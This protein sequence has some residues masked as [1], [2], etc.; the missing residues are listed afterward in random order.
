MSRQ[1]QARLPDDVFVALEAIRLDY[2]KSRLAQRASAKPP[3]MGDVLRPLLQAHGI[4]PAPK[5]DDEKWEYVTIQRLISLHSAVQDG[6]ALPTDE[7]L[8]PGLKP[9]P[10]RAPAEAGAEGSRA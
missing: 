9:G 1:H 4:L 10:I 6:D 5:G 2:A 7:A 8:P 3:S